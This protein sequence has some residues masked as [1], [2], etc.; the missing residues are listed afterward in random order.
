MDRNHLQEQ[1]SYI[2]ELKRRAEASLCAAPEGSLRV[3][4]NKGRYPQYYLWPER[5]YLKKQDADLIRQLAQKEYD[6]RILQVLGQQ[7]KAIMYYLKN[8]PAEDLTDVYEHLPEAKKMVV[9]PYILTDEQ[10][11]ENWQNT[12]APGRN[13]YPI[14]NGFLTERG[15]LVRSKS[16][17][18]I[19]DKLLYMQIPYKYE[20]PL[21]LGQGRTAGKNEGPLNLGQ[22]RIAGEYEE[23]LNLGHSRTAGKVPDK[24]EEMSMLVKNTDLYKHEEIRPQGTGRVIYPDFTLLDIRRRRTIY[25]E[26]FGMMDNPEYC[27]KA[28]EKLELYQANGIYPGKNLIVTMESSLKSIDLRALEQ[29]LGK[30]LG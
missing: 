5:T 8:F 17:K 4:M 24:N 7:E 20:E 23:P 19:A 12:Q 6:E 2:R 10:Y 22:N 25:L 16:E 26:H 29:L 27:K 11:L 14:E 3:E 18:I 1:L 15:E 13:T 21:N 28:I 9:K 30:I